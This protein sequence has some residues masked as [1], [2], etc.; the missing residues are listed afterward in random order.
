[1]ELKLDIEKLLDY[2]RSFYILTKLRIAIFDNDGKRL[3][4]Y[5]LEDS[6]FCKRVK[7]E[8]GLLN[9]CLESDK[10]SFEECKKKN[11]ISLYKCHAHLS[12]ATAVLKSNG[13]VVGYLMIGQ[14][15]DIK[16]KSERI[17]QIRKALH[18]NEEQTKSFR[19]DI[20]SIKFK[21][22]E[23]IKAAVK[24]LE[25]L[26]NYLMLEEYISLNR[27]RFVN[28]LD[29]YIEDNIDKNINVNDICKHFNYGRTKIY[30]FSNNYLNM[31]LAHYISLYKIEK[32]KKLLITTNQKVIDIAFDLGFSD[33]NYFCRIF[34]KATYKTPL[35]YR[36]KNK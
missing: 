34:K 26:A 25:A 32:A 35:E 6:V 28:E 12:E 18:L 1:M 30:E 14:C 23:Q 9:K 3:C 29:E 11:H 22:D 17:T 13:I 8:L 5:P 33:Y 7:Y 36:T 16:D 4:S 19:E 24:I 21:D 15:I 27:N 31:S 2:L 20:D 10:K